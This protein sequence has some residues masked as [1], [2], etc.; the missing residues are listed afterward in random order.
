MAKRR[1]PILVKLKAELKQHGIKPEIYFG[2]KHIRIYWTH[3][4]ESRHHTV[5]G[6]PGDWRTERNNIAQLRRQLRADGH[7]SNTNVAE[8]GE[9]A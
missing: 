7:I 2:K 9:A 1:N 3:R 5:P 8:H 4:G 6:S